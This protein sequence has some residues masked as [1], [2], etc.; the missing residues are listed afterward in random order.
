M[1]WIGGLNGLLVQGNVEVVN[2]LSY[3][4]AQEPKMIGPV[5]VNKK[6]L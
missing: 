3:Y 6:G 2:K 4:L 1:F 5:R